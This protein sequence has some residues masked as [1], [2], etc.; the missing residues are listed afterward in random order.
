MNSTRRLDNPLKVSITG[1][2]NETSNEDLWYQLRLGNQKAIEDLYRMNYQVLYSYAY[3]ICRDKEMS[4]DC[5]QELFVR[6][7]EKRDQLREVSK[8][9]PYLL[10]SIWH[11][12]IRKLKS[13]HKNLAID[14]NTHYNMDVVF[15][16]ESIQI[17]QD[18]TNEKN[19]RLNDALNTLSARQRQIIF[20]QYYEGLTIEEIQES[21]EL[22]YQSIKILTH[23]AML[24]LRGKFHMKK[25]TGE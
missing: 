1:Q 7:W 9:R 17:S 2:R 12:V 4:K 13:T 5:V 18:L 24:I 23:R 8:V 6:L 15:S 11:A 10:Q 3:K 21:T 22:K 19:R 14:E 16:S 20:M 25:N